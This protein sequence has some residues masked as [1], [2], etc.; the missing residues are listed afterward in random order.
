MKRSLVYLFIISVVFSSCIKTEEVSPIPE[1]AFK[2]L[3]VGLVYDSLLEQYL[4][5]GELEFTFI[6]GDA[7]IGIYEGSVDTVTWNENNY[8]VFLH[9]YQKID[10]SYIAI[11]LD[12]SMPPPYY[13]IW[14]D[15]KLD[16]VGQNKTIKGTISI[17]ILDL[18]PYDTIRYEFF[19][20]DRA[21]HNSNIETTTD[22]GTQLDQSSL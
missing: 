9:P 20:R 4:T 21:G 12:S 2:S 15:D 19:I 7:D 14:H 3:E 22:I 8:N 11:E 6:D 10:T 1:I 18:P 17:I 16:R 5:A 13:T